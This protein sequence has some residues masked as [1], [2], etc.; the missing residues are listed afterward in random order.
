MLMTAL[1]RDLRHAAR[2]L[3][4]EPRFTAATV[5]ILAVGIGACTAMFSIVHAVL[6]RPM[7]LPAA[8]RV[9][10]L[11]SIDVRHNAVIESTYETEADFR[12]RLRSFDDVA[13]MGSVNWG[14]A[15]TIPGR[16]PV[17]LSAAVVSGTFFQL[18]GS[19]PLLGRVFDAKD[20]DPQAERRLVLSHAAWTQFFGADPSV[21]GRRV[22]VRE[23]ATPQPFEVI[24]VMPP[25]FFF[26]RGAQY[27]TTAAPR[28]EAIAR[29]TGQPRADLFG[30]LGVFYALGRLRPGVSID[31]A[32]REMPSYL[33]SVADQFRIDLSSFRI[34]VTPLLDFIFGAARQALWLLMAAVVLVLLIACGNV[35]GLVFA[36]GAARR[37]EIAVRFA[38]GAGRG[39]LVRQLLAESAFIACLGGLLGVGAAA[40]VLRSLVALSPAD[41]TR[42]DDTGIN[43]AV[44][45]FAVATAFVATVLVGLA[46]ALRFSRVSLV[47]D[48]KSGSMG[49]GQAAAPGRGALVAVQV[50]GTL[51]LLIAAGLCVRS[52]ARLS[53]LDLGFNPAQVLTFSVI[54]LNEEQFPSRE[55]RHELVERLI[56][57]LEALPQVRTAG[58]VFQ[59]PFE[60][61]P[62]GMDAGVLLEGQPDTPDES[63]RN[64]VVNWES[65]TRDYFAS[66]GIRLLRG[67]LFDV[68]DNAAAGRVAVVSEAAANHLW[69]GQDPLGK[70]LRLSL[71]ESEDRWLTVVGVVATAR[72][73]EIATP[74]FDLYVPMRQSTSDVQ[75]FTVRT[76]DDPLSATAAID[77]AV[78][79]AD[80]RLSIGGVTTMAS[81][82]SRVRGPWHFSLIVFALFGFIALALAVVGLFAV[83][84][85]AV[86]QRSREI[87]V[88]MALG[89]SPRHVIALMLA[90]GT[91]PATAGLLLGAVAASALTRTVEPLLFEVRAADPLTFAAVL[92]S[93]AAVIATASYLPARRAARVDPQIV[94]RQE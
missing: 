4:R 44:V 34:V 25:E 28:L 77:A 39:A 90:H 6:L 79:N 46:P 86:T 83:V 91:R 84:S 31:D 73:R 7:A 45:L 48:M 24:G 57:N 33:K 81:V 20:D 29:Q 71:T 50:A 61:G 1:L 93:F 51:V 17:H 52:F 63:N 66:M 43:L 30:K 14:G 80:P 12:R 22:M 23:D 2:R 82:V 94:L 36:R 65:V 21:I 10:M 74:R 41:I 67:R 11:W 42:L 59:R 54:G 58:A 70:R 3:A 76:T 15:L 19:G 87:G 18:L 53:N 64:G 62:I 37:R 72:Y 75:H 68:R 40:A 16:D 89:A 56:A 47:D 27:W 13:L 85:Y 38:L 9:V 35:A 49:A 78:R 69:P 92:T 26:P 32:R 60:H 88:R 5:L 55:A 8:D